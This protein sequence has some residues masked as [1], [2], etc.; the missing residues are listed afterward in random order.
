MKFLVDAQLP[1][2]LARWLSACGHVALH[3]SDVDMSS[4]DDDAIWDF[5]ATEQAVIMTKDEDFATRRVLS[6]DGPVIVW[7]RLG[8]SR[9][10][11]LIGWLERGLPFVIEAIER[12]E[13]LIELV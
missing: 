12:G 9:N 2:A 3:V 6:Q 8:N 7:V 1:I 5:A 10:A 4:A 13:T 11:V